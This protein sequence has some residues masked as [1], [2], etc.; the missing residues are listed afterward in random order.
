M[1]QE[2]LEYMKNTPRRDGR[3]S[4]VLLFPDGNVDGRLFFF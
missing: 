2:V 4:K 1:G 3:Q